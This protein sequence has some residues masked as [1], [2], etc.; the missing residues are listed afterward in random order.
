[1]AIFRRLEASAIEAALDI[2][3]RKLNQLIH[4]PAGPYNSLSYVLAA[5]GIL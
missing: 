2:A 4:M 1:M 5:A 3:V